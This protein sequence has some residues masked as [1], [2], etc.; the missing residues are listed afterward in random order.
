MASSQLYFNALL[1]YLVILFFKKKMYSILL[2]IS[3]GNAIR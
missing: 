1:F 2:E 3:L